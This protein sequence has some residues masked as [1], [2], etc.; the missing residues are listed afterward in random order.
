MH[1][2]GYGCETNAGAF[3]IFVAVKTVKGR[4]EPIGI[5]HIETSAVVAHEI[6]I[7]G[8]V[9]SEFDEG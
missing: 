5:G 8:W 1:D 9:L 6:G 4:E 7:L 2:A 3:E